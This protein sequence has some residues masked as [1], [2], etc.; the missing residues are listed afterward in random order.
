[1]LQIL[2]FQIHL[3]YLKNYPNMITLRTFSK[4]YGL[5]S[6]RVG[7]GM[8]N[9]EMVTYFNRIIGPFDVN[10]Y[11]QQAAVASLKDEEFLTRVYETNK[12]GKEY[13][14]AQF[15]EMELPYIKTNANF[16][17]V[18]TKTSSEEVFDKLLRQGIIIRP[19]H[20]LGMPGW[21]RVTIGTMEQ[22]KKFIECL[23]KAL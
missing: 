7:Y 5:A 12:E 8:A 2:R 21:L 16:V 19:G 11:A 9:E 10:L 1:M 23:K 3:N 13:L 14:Y 22:N 20:L 4:A 17:M 18:D 15:E 6:L